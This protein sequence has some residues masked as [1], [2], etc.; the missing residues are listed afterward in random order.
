[1]LIDKNTESFPYREWWKINRDG[2]RSDWL[3]LGFESKHHAD[4][5][6]GSMLGGDHTIDSISRRKTNPEDTA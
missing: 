6:S 3:D 2:M 4:I 1:M 5:V